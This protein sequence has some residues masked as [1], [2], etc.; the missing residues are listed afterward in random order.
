MHLT[1]ISQM[2]SKRGFE[3][4][5]WQ[6][7]MVLLSAILDPRKDVGSCC[8][9]LSLVQFSMQSFFTT[10]LIG[11]WW[12]KNLNLS[13]TFFTTTSITPI[14]FLN[15]CFPLK[16]WLRI[17]CVPETLNRSSPSYSWIVF[18]ELPLYLFLLQIVKNVYLFTSIKLPCF[19]CITWLYTESAWQHIHHVFLLFPTPDFGFL[20]EQ[21]VKTRN[22]PSGSIKKHQKIENIWP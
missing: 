19:D 11:C 5:F 14:K 1:R 17:K 3:N 9:N 18:V 7:D 12:Q 13:P 4:K 16:T 10:I 6:Y 8:N 22:Y 20:I 21:H 15:G 2:L